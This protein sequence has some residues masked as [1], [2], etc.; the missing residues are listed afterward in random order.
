MQEL[1]FAC[2]LRARHQ[3]GDQGCN[4]IWLLSSVRRLGAGRDDVDDKPCHGIDT[5]NIL[6][7]HVLHMHPR[8]G[9]ARQD[10][11]SAP[12]TLASSRRIGSLSPSTCDRQ[13]PAP[14]FSPRRKWGIPTKTGETSILVDATIQKAPQAPLQS[15]QLHPLCTPAPPNSPGELLKLF[16][17]QL[18]PCPMTSVAF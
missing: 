17:L 1:R 18:R 12:I 13:L 8:L 5:G 15:A 6:A 16:L 7:K 10:V 2:S 4:G 11:R 14:S 9:T 3:T